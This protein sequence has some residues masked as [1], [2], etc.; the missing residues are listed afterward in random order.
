[1]NNLKQNAQTA[2]KWS[3]ILTFGN[4]CV[5]FLISVILARLQEPWEL[6]TAHCST[7]TWNSKNKLFSPFPSLLSPGLSAFF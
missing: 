6:Y 2:V 7:P 5:S 3:A 4:Q 1:M